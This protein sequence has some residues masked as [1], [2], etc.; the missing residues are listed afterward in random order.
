MADV[1]VDRS[2]AVPLGFGMAVSMWAVAYVC[3]LPVVM[4][5]AW[6][7]MVLLLAAVAW[8]GAA[9]GRWTGDGWSAGA[10]GGLVAAIIN[11][12]ILG[13]LLTS[14]ATGEVTP[15][16]LIWV[17]GSILAVV[18]LAAAASAFGSRGP[19][20][21]GGRNW[22]GLLAKVALAATFLLVVAGG[23]VTSYEAGLAVVDW[24]NTFGT[25]MFLYPLSRMTGGVYYE[26]AHRLFGA[27][28][29][30]TTIALALRLWRFDH[31][32]WLRRLAVGA[33]GVVVVQGILGGLRVT[34][35]FTFSTSEADM[36]PSIALAVVHGVLGQVFL[37]L[38][39]AMAVATS[40]AWLE[41]PP[42]ERRAG[43]S[44][45]RTLQASLVA[46]LVVQ[47]VL[48]AIQRHL[49]EGLIIHISLA[50]VVVVIA[51]VAG[52]RAWG[53]HHGVR[54]VQRIG[55]LLMAVVTVQ[56]ALGIAALAVTQGRAV[57]GQPTTLE[58]TIA[59]AHQATGAFLLALAVA[60]A[61][62]TR[63]LFEPE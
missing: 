46:V 11:M 1:A 44:G 20:V 57:V 13:S 9:A 3:R 26:H 33:V 22:T 32:R 28:V 41:A 52:A 34:G 55:Q 8:W 53:L 45:D 30:L 14:E 17:P 12:L 61:V 39:A 38:V 49:A 42:A 15:S 10:R 4:A 63:R 43:A 5:P 60:L 58:A 23:L 48:G 21:G 40:S 29:G 51:V 18:A 50:A 24:P 59:T 37:G 7:L 6:L 16:A 25:N 31:R 36:A 54:P 47:L 27:L 35:G 56:V 62:W 19:L 2:Y